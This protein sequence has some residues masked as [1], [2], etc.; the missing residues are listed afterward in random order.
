MVECGPFLMAAVAFATASTAL[1]AFSSLRTPLPCARG[2]EALAAGRCDG[3][4]VEL[5]KTWADAFLAG[6]CLEICST[7][8]SDT[9]PELAG[10]AAIA[11]FFSFR[12]ARLRWVFVIGVA[13]DV[14][15]PDSSA[16]VPSDHCVAVT[17]PK[18]LLLYAAPSEA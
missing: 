9:T 8:D 12:L 17:L 18:P 6:V 11:A 1:L 16:S 4:G 13:V 10:R 3:V 7:S 5:R 14:T 2:V 15:E